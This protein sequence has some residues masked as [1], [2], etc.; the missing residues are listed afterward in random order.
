M[1]TFGL[2]NIL[3]GYTSFSTFSSLDCNEFNR[4]PSNYQY[5]QMFYKISVLTSNGTK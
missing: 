3:F 5:N 1:K 2:Q 4:V